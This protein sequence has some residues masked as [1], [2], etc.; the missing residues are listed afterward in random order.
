[1]KR[2][3]PTISPGIYQIQSKINEKLYIG[4]AINLK[5]RKKNHF[6]ELKRREHPNIILQNH[7]N[8]YG[9]NVLIFSILE[10]CL[11]EKLIEREQ[12][13]MDTLNPEF[14][15]RKIAGSCL[16]MKH[17]E[18]AKQKM[19]AWQTGKG[20]YWYGKHLS[21]ETKQKIR[22]ASGNF[23]HSEE[24]KRKLSEI[25]KGKQHRKGTLCSEETKRKISISKKGKNHPMY[26][27][28]PS[29]ETKRKIKETKAHNKKTWTLS[30]ETKRKMS[31]AKK[32][33]IYS[34]E[35]K[36]KMSTIKKELYRKRKLLKTT[37]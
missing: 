28:I 3:T 13:Y 27:K 2:T 31:I 7:V 24:T 34:E 35:Y 4:S 25:N 22:I 21:E 30:E 26:G 9:I 17:S 12:Y 32:G 6:N 33:T 5:T 8:K 23:K 29:E 1:M 20:G 10:F 19:S 16:G 14:N 18:K 15:I 11:K 37:V 36:K